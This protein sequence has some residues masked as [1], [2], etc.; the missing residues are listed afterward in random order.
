VA[1]VM[2]PAASLLAERGGIQRGSTERMSSL[3]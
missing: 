1:T 3:S 2:S